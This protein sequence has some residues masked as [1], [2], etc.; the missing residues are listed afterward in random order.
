MFNNFKDYKKRCRG[1]RRSSLTTVIKTRVRKRGTAEEVGGG[2]RA[3][4]NPRINMQGVTQNENVVQA[5]FNDELYLHGAQSEASVHCVTHNAPLFCLPVKPWPYLLR[6]NRLIKVKS[7]K[8][9]KGKKNLFQKAAK[10]SKSVE[11]H[12]VRRSLGAELV[13][14]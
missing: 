6:M 8:G 1:A 2:V 7:D 12:R 5:Y 10:R 4:L 3:E 14:V 11:A 13:F 9:D